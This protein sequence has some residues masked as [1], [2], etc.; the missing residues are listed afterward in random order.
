MNANGL[1]IVGAIF[2]IVAMVVFVFS[3]VK[4]PEAVEDEAGFHYVKDP[5]SAGKRR[6]AATR[7]ATRAPHIAKSFKPHLPSTASAAPWDF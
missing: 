1:I 5:K 2:A 7:T 4:A 6:S 3:L